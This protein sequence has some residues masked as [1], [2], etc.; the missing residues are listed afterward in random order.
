[1]TELCR[2]NL[3]LQFRINIV[4]LLLSWLVYITPITSFFLLPLLK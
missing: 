3:V 1:M 4:S 2:T